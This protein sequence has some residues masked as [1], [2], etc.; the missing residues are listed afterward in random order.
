MDKLNKY[1]INNFFHT[2]IILF[3]ILF[4]ISSMI[5]LLT[6]SNVTMMLKINISEFLY[7]YFLSLPEIIFFTIPLS[8]F[9]AASITI[10]KLFENS[11]LLSVL[12]LGVSPKKILKP[13]LYISIFITII[14]LI[15]TFFSVPASSILYK[16]FF[17]IKKAE[18]NFNFLVS[19]TGQKF[20]EWSLFAQKKVNK[21]YH[22]IVMYNNKKKILI[23]API[24]YT[25]KKDNIFS[26]IL[27]NGHIYNKNKKTNYIKFKKLKINE[28]INITNLSFQTIG[29]YIK[30]NK[31]KT[32]KYFLISFFPLIAYFFI[33]GISFF[34]NRYQKNYSIIYT[35]AISIAYYIAAF[36]LHKNLY[37]IFYIVPIFIIIGIIFSKKRI[38]RF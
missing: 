3:G 30:T 14:S 33:G 23:T 4:V 17:N 5:L 2:F 1:L 7:L 37:S 36:V 6:I 9:I 19:S 34:H 22:N 21:K 12:S 15:I 29:Q 10:A 20:G 26:L 25:T 32:N 18:S 28:K 24:G 13:F 16:N 8:F 27:L 35:L 31:D 11:E 38:K